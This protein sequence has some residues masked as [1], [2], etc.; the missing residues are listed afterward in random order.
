MLA[1]PEDATA[2]H[3][4]HHLQVVTGCLF[5]WAQKSASTEDAARRAALEL[6]SI[7][8]GAEVQI[9][10]KNNS[11]YGNFGQYHDYHLVF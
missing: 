10:G 4:T 8:A 1:V 9:S 3:R 2:F 6:T 5:Q 11:G 7:V